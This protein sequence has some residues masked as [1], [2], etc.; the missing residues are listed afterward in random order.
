MNPFDP[1]ST[2]P[3]SFKMSLP[4]AHAVQR[5]LIRD[6]SALLWERMHCAS[7]GRLPSTSSFS[8]VSSVARRAT[9]QHAVSTAATPPGA[10]L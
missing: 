5:H 1:E 4:E 7:R 10:E 2:T 8:G 6:E 9:S 3:L